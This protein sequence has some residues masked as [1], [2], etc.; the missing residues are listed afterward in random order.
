MS[1]IIEFD[2]TT[3][4]ISDVSTLTG[5]AL[6]TD[7]IL[8]VSDI[9]FEGDI[10]VPVDPMSTVETLITAEAYAALDSVTNTETQLITNITVPVDA[11]IAQDLGIADATV[12]ILSDSLSTLDTSTMRDVYVPVDVTLTSDGLTFA[13]SVALSDILALT[14]VS[15]TTIE[16]RNTDVTTLAVSTQNWIVNYRP[17]DALNTFDVSTLTLTQFELETLTAQDIAA[18]IGYGLLDVSLSISEA[19]NFS[20]KVYVT[21]QG[22]IFS[23]TVN[24]Q[25]S[26]GR[27]N[28]QIFSGKIQGVLP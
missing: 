17:V 24:G 23:G 8:V 4:T 28:G 22:T 20:A 27:V 26:N 11:L 7:N 13:L 9:V 21:V 12:E 10:F 16:D 1:T 6:N 2:L 14:D 18:S 19:L 25:I 5:I 3:L 15:T